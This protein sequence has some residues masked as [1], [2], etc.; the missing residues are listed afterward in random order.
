MI[1]LHCKAGGETDGSQNVVL[2]IQVEEGWTPVELKTWSYRTIIGCLETRVG[3][4]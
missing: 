3:G 2:L 1:V 4:N